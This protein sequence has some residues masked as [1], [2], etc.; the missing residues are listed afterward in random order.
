MYQG[1]KDV[2]FEVAGNLEARLDLNLV[3]EGLDYYF[4]A[5]R[6]ELFDEYNASV[7]ITSLVHGEQ[8]LVVR[9]IA[10][11]IDQYSSKYDFDL[12]QALASDEYKE[13]LTRH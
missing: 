13:F 8:E 10:D 12:L 6:V 11:F 7:S 3:T 4:N 1:H 5:D 9:R 2:R